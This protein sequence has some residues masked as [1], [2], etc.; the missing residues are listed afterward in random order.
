[1]TAIVVTSPGHDYTSAPNVTLS[2]GGG[3][4]A[5]AVGNANN[6]TVA[7]ARVTSV[8]SGY[9]SPPTAT[10]SGGGGSGAA[11][12]ANLASVILASDTMIGGPGTIDIGGQVRG[13][14]LLRKGSAGTLILSGVNTYTGITI[15]SNG[16]LALGVN[17]S[18]GSSP[19]IDVRSNAVFDVSAVGGGYVLGASQTLKGSGTVLGN[20]TANGVIA[21][22]GSVGTLNI[23]GDLTVAGDLVIEL[24]KSLSPSNDVVMVSGALNNTGAGSVTVTN[25]GPGLVAGDSFQIFNK[26][27]V[28]GGGMAV[29]SPG[30]VWSN[31]LALDGSIA[32]V[33]VTAPVAATNLMIQTLGPTSFGLSAMGAGDSLYGVLASTNLALPLSNWWLIGT[34]LSDPG[35][36]IEYVDAQ[37]TNSQ[38][39]YRFVQ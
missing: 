22:G 1:V 32:V 8:G 30:V 35:G 31:N 15:V 16:V 2:G 10:L 7:G 39:F 25:L 36:L 3:V 33:S 23:D 18:M 24:D 26:A 29:V 21:P 28:N 11:A 13:S 19:V 14:G 9:A 34:T 38:R 5:T 20:V 12:V 17:G 4:G 37:A 6:F 27:L